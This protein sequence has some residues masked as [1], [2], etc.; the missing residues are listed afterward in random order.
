MTG[1]NELLSGTQTQM[2][3]RAGGVRIQALYRGVPRSPR[4]WP[5][6]TLTQYCQNFLFFKKSSD[7][8]CS[9]EISRFL[10]I[11]FKMLS[12]AEF[13]PLAANL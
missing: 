11:A 10:K 1:A 2:P 6:G 3:H 9:Y 12:T 4:S 13:N 7:S 5:H 8:H